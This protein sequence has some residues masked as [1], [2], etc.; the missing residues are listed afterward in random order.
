MQDIANG[1]GRPTVKLEYIEE[2][3]LEQGQYYQQQTQLTYAGDGTQVTLVGG[4]C[5]HHCTIP[6]PNTWLKV[7]VISIAEVYSVSQSSE[8][9]QRRQHS[10]MCMQP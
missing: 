4:K 6:L 10:L 5:S 8:L 2:N 7:V 9:R 3:F 1:V